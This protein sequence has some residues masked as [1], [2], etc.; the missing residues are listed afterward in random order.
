MVIVW[1]LLAGC[2]DG[3]GSDS[4]ILENTED[5]EDTDTHSGC[6]ES[7]PVHWEDDESTGSDCDDRL[8]ICLGDPLGA[9][10]WVFGMAETGVDDGWMGEDCLNG[11]GDTQVCHPIGDGVDRVLTQVCSSAEVIAGSTTFLD[12]GREPFLTYYLSDAED[13][14]VWGHDITYYA[15][16]GCTEMS[17]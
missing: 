17:R 11:D 15:G 5:T 16:L 12:A 7:V 13:C 4:I 6:G 14:F 3:P 8:N 1:L 10:D 2:V 9:M